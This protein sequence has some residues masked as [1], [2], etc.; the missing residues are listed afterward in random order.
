MSL[1]DISD[2]GTPGNIS[3]PEVKLVSADGTWGAAPWESRSL[4]R[5]FSFNKRD[6]VD[7]GFSFNSL[8]AFATSE[9]PGLPIADLRRSVSKPAQTA[10]PGGCRL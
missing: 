3:N 9:A 7:S 2:E 8:F 4:P 1:G 5:D 6:R 10:P